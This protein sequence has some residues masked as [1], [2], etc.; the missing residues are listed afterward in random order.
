VPSIFISYRRDDSWDATWRI[1]EH[2][3]QRFGPGEIFI[4]VDNIP[5]GVDFRSY[6]QQT[7]H[8]CQAMLVVIGEQ[9]LNAVD[10]SGR[11]RLD[12][13]DDFVRVELEWAMENR[14]PIVPVLIRRAAMPG[15]KHLPAHLAELAF[16]NAA[17]VR[18]SGE[19]LHD[20]ER[21][22]KALQDKGVAPK[23]PPSQPV[24]GMP[25]HC[26]DCGQQNQLNRRICGRCR[27]P[28]WE[29]CIEC[30]F[31]N[32]AWDVY[33]GQC[34]EHLLQARQK[35]FD[36]VQQT[37]DQ[38]IAWRED[39]RYEQAVGELERISSLTHPRL[40]PHTEWASQLLPILRAEWT[41]AQQCR[42]RLIAEAH[43][44]LA[45]TRF[46]D[47]VAALQGIPRGL[48][49]AKDEQLLAAAS[50]K[51]A[52]VEELCNRVGQSLE[53]HNLADAWS[54]A[55]ALWE[56]APRLDF[57]RARL[58]AALDVTYR[59]ASANFDAQKYDL[60]GNTLQL[61]PV[62]LRNEAVS[63]LLERTISRQAELKALAEQ[64]R[65]RLV[66]DARQFLGERRFAE[67]VDALQGVP[68][69]LRSAEEEQLLKATGQ[70]LAAVEELCHGVQQ[71]LAV[72]D[73]AEVWRHAAALWA[74]EPDLDFVR[75][76][77]DV[78][79][80]RT[81]QAAN[82]EFAAHK[83]ERAANLL[84]LVPAVLRNE[85]M[86]QLLQDATGKQSELRNL[87]EQIREAQRSGATSQLLIL[88]PRFLDLQPDHK[89]GRA[90]LEVSLRQAT[91]AALGA[92]AENKDPALVLELMNVIPPA[93]RSEDLREL[94][95]QLLEQIAE[96]ERQRPYREVQAEYE[97]L[98]AT[99][100]AGLRTPAQCDAV[101]GR[102]STLDGR[103]AQLAPGVLA[104]DVQR[105]RDA[106]RQSLKQLQEMR[107]RLVDQA[108]VRDLCDRCQEASLRHRRI[109][110][111]WD[112]QE[113]IRC[114]LSARQDATR[115]L[116]ML[117][118]PAARKT[119]DKVIEGLNGILRNLS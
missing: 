6:I 65:Q 86:V 117:K 22:I 105:L 104:D 61:V 7:L 33:C 31:D 76:R 103:I 106:V 62:A 96:A 4:D 85:A 14:V 32:G 37:R 113:T 49:T 79:L 44:S 78:A 84:E 13:E 8:G 114:A 90:L 92:W 74:L 1:H 101:L 38:I 28:L 81:C 82:I 34:G 80:D 16:I 2:L 66:A 100:K 98:R 26:P 107:P 45:E 75:A 27:E 56:L 55:T 68:S 95:T 25:G 42:E 64:R 94:Q 53:A 72:P 93:I 115:A 87:A 63:S 108:I 36:A 77:L 5:L 15:A 29:P 50:Q 52:E 19:F 24:A 20:M 99:I 88:L 58:A 109:R 43:R 73:W 35:R 97:G 102:M 41:E 48:R 39:R 47:A 112:A 116:Q 60:A 83:Y 40:K 67:A 3:Q 30:S 17:T 46:A 23:V 59:E 18:S 10:E 54:H 11:R 12:Q 71:A 89:T 118:D 119:L 69:G 9:W 51:L 111:S 110:T 21:L 57:A 91:D 70:K